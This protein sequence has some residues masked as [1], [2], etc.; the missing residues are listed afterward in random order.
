MRHAAH[1]FHLSWWWWLAAVV[2]LLNGLRPPD[3]WEGLIAIVAG[4]FVVG[5]AIGSVITRWWTSWRRGSALEHI[6]RLRTRAVELRNRGLM[7]I[8]TEDDL[9]SWMKERDQLR[10]EMLGAVQ[11]LSTHEA[12]GF[13]TLGH[14]ADNDIVV[15]QFSYLH[16]EHQRQVAFLTADARRLDEIRKR[17]S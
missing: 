3:T 16:A 5:G 12:L 13:K 8:K 11:K 15:G 6:A 9:A 17:Y 7:E 14:L 1:R 4:V 2:V 10:E